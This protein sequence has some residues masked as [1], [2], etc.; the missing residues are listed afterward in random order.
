MTISEVSNDA[1]VPAVS[2]ESIAGG[3]GL[4][5]KGRRG[6]VGESDTFQGVFGK[7]RDN[8]GIVGES[9]LFHAVFGI[10]HSVN[11]GGLF[12]ANDA[13]GFGVIGTCD[14][15]I[16]VAGDSKTG[17]G[18]RGVSQTGE[19]VHGETNSNVFAA[20]AGIQLNRNSTGAGVYG[21][22]R[23]TGPAGFF[24]G[25]VLVTGDIKLINAD[26]AE[27]FDI[28]DLEKAEPGTV[29][30]IDSEGALR[31][32]DRPYD[33]RV[34]GVISGAGNYKPGLI[35]DKQESS[36][37][38]MPI[39]LMGKVYCKVDA[40][41]GAIEI[42]DLLTTSPTLGHGMKA[43]DP[44]KSFGAVIGKALRPL[45]EGQGLIPILIALQ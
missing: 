41:Y 12:G 14:S 8:A 21:E 7:S 25:D 40:S 28:A 13:G 27:D 10:S 22:H 19:G 9:A 43:D 35:L 16:G 45:D 24:K 2:G 44:L 1:S 29:M 31:S 39:A 23:G 17:T 32:S 42:G 38:R 18:V 3:D 5:G 33:K 15:N 36:N 37:D 20:V 34:A 11:N 6:V 30:V 26:C 4:V